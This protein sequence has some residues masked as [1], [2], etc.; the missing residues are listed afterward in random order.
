MFSGHKYSVKMVIMKGKTYTLFVA[1]VVGI[2][3]LAC[4]PIIVDPMINTDK[5]SKSHF[6]NMNIS[7]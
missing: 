5:Y 6:V 3:G 4:Y 2:I 7:H 1:G